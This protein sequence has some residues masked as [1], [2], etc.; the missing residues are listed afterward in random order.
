MALRACSFGLLDKENEG[1]E[2]HKFDVVIRRIASGGRPHEGKEERKKK[3]AA[4]RGNFGA[5]E[6][7]SMG[8]QYYHISPK[9]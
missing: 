7:T 9:N 2:L 1:N 4:K 3:E 5:T 6:A 8:G